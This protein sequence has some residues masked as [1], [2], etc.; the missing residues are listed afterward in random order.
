MNSI[1][2][3]LKELDTPC[4][5]IDL[6][7]LK[8]NI[9]VM[10]EYAAQVGVAVRPHCKTHKCSRIAKLQIEAGAL[11]I[12]AAKLSEAEV[13]IEQGIRNVLITSPIVSEP[14]LNRLARCLEK[15][16]K[17][18]LVLDNPE[19]AEALNQLGQALSQPIQVLIDLDPG[20]GR[21][22]IPP[23]AAIDFARLLQK[24]SWLQVQGV[25]SHNIPVDPMWTAKDNTRRT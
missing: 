3:K 16:P 7:R 1:V 23:N 25:L 5:L 18:L 9:H 24:K 22:G 6:D 19:N 15:A 20:I 12:S 2:R 14:K 4:L 10:Q 21:T 13:L 17:S 8:E 11:G